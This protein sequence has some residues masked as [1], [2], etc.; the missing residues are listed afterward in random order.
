MG[1]HRT[2]EEKVELGERARAMR[3]AG[4]PRREIL[5]TL[6]IGDDLANELLRGTEPP[7]SL[8]RPRAKDEVRQR[9]RELRQ[10]GWMYPRIAA[11]L[12]VSKSSCSLW[13]RDMDHPEPSVEGQERR[14]AAIRASAARTQQLREIERASVKNQAARRVGVLTDRELELIAVA[15]YWWEGSKDKP[16]ARRERVIFI[17]S[18]PGLIALWMEFLLRQGFGVADVRLYL[19]IHVSA[20][21]DRATRFWA[22]VVGVD[23]SYLRRPHLKRHNPRTV[24]KNTGDAYVGCLVVQLLGGREFYQ[25]IEGMWRGIVAGTF[26]RP[27]AWH[28]EGP[29]VVG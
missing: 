24:R 17:N 22:D 21:V 16:Y 20:D 9:A 8:R 5:S 10:A 12:G 18:D 23:P 11:A 28:P 26:P 7:D 25:R 27:P 4:R 29:S 13:L 14:T 3:T 2:D 19:S 1:R 6:G 15:A